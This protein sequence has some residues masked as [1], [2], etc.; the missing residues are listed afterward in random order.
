MIKR[1]I[2]V[3]WAKE[4]WIDWWGWEGW[5]AVR[6]LK[7]SGDMQVGGCFTGVD[8]CDWARGKI[9]MVLELV[10]TVDNFR[11]LLCKLWRI[12]VRL[13]FIAEVTFWCKMT[14]RGCAIMSWKWRIHKLSSDLIWW[15]KDF[16]EGKFVAC[17]LGKCRSEG[18]D[19]F[20]ARWLGYFLAF[21]HSSSKSCGY[22]PLYL[23]ESWGCLKDATLSIC[24]R[25]EGCC[26][27]RTRWRFVGIE[28]NES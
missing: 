6:P 17:T 11:Y 18:W 4:G 7:D 24:S 15:M 9:G 25:V 14:W 13:C 27:S 26:G 1:K 21:S 28:P 3:F 20:M 5:G 23:L 12:L 19:V 10:W 16:F 8:W 2:F 22:S